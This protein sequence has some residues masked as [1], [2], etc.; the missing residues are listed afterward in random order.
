MLSDGGSRALVARVVLDLQTWTWTGTGAR[1]EKWVLVLVRTVP[2]VYVSSKVVSTVDWGRLAGLGRVRER[3]C[4]C[5][6]FDKASSSTQSVCPAQVKSKICSDPPQPASQP[7]HL[8]VPQ[9]SAVL[10]RPV[11]SVQRQ[12]NL[13]IQEAPPPQIPMFK[14]DPVSQEETLASNRYGTVYG[15]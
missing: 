4:V 8:S 2:C 15:R 14:R 1:K 6:L 7:A 9:S 12:P 13:H 11:S 5:S 10:Q 3:V